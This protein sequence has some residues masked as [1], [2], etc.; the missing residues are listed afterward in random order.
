MQLPATFGKYE[1]LERIATGGMAEVYLARTFGV[2]GFEKRLV[3]KRIRPELAGDPHH[4]QLFIDEARIG[5]QLGHENVVQIF[6]LGRVGRDWYIAMEHLHGRDLNKLVK[7]LRAEG[8]R[9]PVP[10]AVHV[11]AEVCRGL[12]H[13]HAL[14]DAD[15]RALGLVHR[16]VSPHNVLLTFAGGV[17]LLDFGIA[18]LVGAK[19]PAPSDAA[20]GRPGGGKYAYMSPEQARGEPV[21]HRTDVFSSGIVLWELLVGHRLYQHHDP[22]EKL[23]LVRDAVIPDPRL[24]GVEIEPGLAEILGRALARAPSD[25]YPSAALLEEDLRAWLYEHGGV[26]PRRTLVEL[27]ERAFPTAA[28]TRSQARPLQQMVADVAR[29]GAG[30]RTGG[31]T[32]AQTPA[33]AGRREAAGLPNEERK[34]VVA[35]YVEIEGMTELSRRLEPEDL[36]RR[37]FQILRWLRRTIDPFAGVIQRYVDDHA[38]VLF[39]VPRTRSDDLERALECA[40]ELRRAVVDLRERGLALRV[41][42]GAHAGDLILDFSRRKT[43]YIQRGDTVELARRL[44]S[45]A[46]DDEILISQ[47]VHD[48]TQ[49]QFRCRAGPDVLRRGGA[50]PIASFA[51]EGRRRGLR[52]SGRGPWLR[53][54]VEV[55]LIQRARGELQEGRSSI[56]AL[57]GDIGSG[58]SRLAREVRDLAVRRGVPVYVTAARPWGERPP[59]EVLRD[60]IVDVLGLD[61]DAPPNRL[62]EAAER[63]GQLGLGPGEVRSIEALLRVPGRAA[64]QDDILRAVER[65]LGG[66]AQDRAAILIL[67]DLQ[68]LAPREHTAIA[69]LLGRLRDLPLLCL[70]TCTG[71]LPEPL[72]ALS[73]AVQL[74]RFDRPQL[75]RLLRALLDA[76]RIDPRLVDLAARTCEGN[77]LYVEEMLK[78]LIQEGHV[79]IDDAEARLTV[80]PSA[81]ALPDSIASLIAARIDA[82]E[83]AAKGALQLAATIGVAFSLSLLGAAMGLDDPSPIAQQ[84]R[85]HGLILPQDDEARDGWAFAS[86]L[87]REAALRSILGVQRRT[88][89]R[90]VAQAIEEAYADNLEPHLEVLAAHCAAAGRA[91]DAAQYIHRAGQRLEE[92][93]FLERARDLYERGLAYLRSAPE[94]PETWDAR[95]QGEAMLSFRSGASSRLLGDERRA[96]RS[97]RLALD[98]A[99][100]A[101]LSWIEV[102]AHLEIG[103]LQVM[104]G[105]FDLAEAHVSQAQS[106]AA[107]EDDA[108]LRR[109]I[110]EARATLSYERG[111]GDEA[112]RWWAEALA[113]A[114]DDPRAVARCKLGMASRHIRDADLDT[115]RRLLD[116]ALVSARAGGD[117][118]LVGRVLNNLGLLH[119]WTGDYDAAL[120]GFRQALQIR[121]GSGYAAGVV[122]NQHNIGDVHLTRGDLA[123]AWVAF[124]RSR[125]L[126]ERMGWRRGIALND[127]YLGLIEASRRGTDIGLDRIRSA[128]AEARAIGDAEIATNGALVAARLLIADRRYDEVRALLAEARA[129]AE[130]HGLSALLTTLEELAADLP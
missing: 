98:I 23:R 126:A 42:I 108:A 13:A 22:L 86:E 18:R 105:R 41:A 43:R 99:S 72:A 110:L 104:R 123:R 81:G 80:A 50:T 79:A 37:R 64:P 119:Y 122:I 60:L 75:E 128:I 39:G 120:A 15:G 62:S 3:I 112:D 57:T 95:T 56:L 66:I 117:R 83:P 4:I 44:A 113:L 121:E 6:D 54:G 17:K 130:R 85:S 114:A 38:L 31:P 93:M 90:L 40:L 84:L 127:V 49:N 45:L 67:E 8:E 74:D 46:D 20:A 19:A 100:D 107:L 124:D 12:A 77:P 16:D 88:Y 101:G 109:E 26:D 92:V 48:A 76:D 129:D 89:N 2:A 94:T 78:Y 21:D 106:L 96:E 5:V 97:L 73:V 103:R 116:E 118:L 30:D 10:V 102:P 34:R 36:L 111:D 82:L 47:R 68:R 9:L 87:V 53:R 25:R 52:V 71:P 7:V 28:G 125:E 33:D 14:H 59:L 70:L 69:T 63:L 32:P 29:L 11:V 51:V 35:M 55:E 91:V 1:L 27:L 58:K 115:A 65:A 24:E 61:S